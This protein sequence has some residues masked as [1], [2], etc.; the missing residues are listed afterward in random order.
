[1][2]CGDCVKNIVSLSF[3]NGKRLSLFSNARFALADATPQL[4][5]D[6][7]GSANVNGFPTRN[8]LLGPHR[9]TIGRSSV[10]WAPNVYDA[11]V[12]Q[13]EL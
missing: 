12:F 4:C 5:P 1:M 8:R 10:D 11:T 9:E 7:V 2:W 13:R 3:Q 6:A